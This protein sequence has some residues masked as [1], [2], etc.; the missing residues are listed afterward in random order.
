VAADERTP[1][2]RHIHSRLIDEE[3]VGKPLARSRL[4]RQRSIEGY[5]KGNAAPRWMSRLAEID[6]GIRRE[7]RELARL[8]A[9]L[10]ERCGADAERFAREWRAVAASR[11]YDHL[12]DLIEVHNE[13]YPIERDLPMNPRTGEYVHINGRPYTR[14]VLGPAWVLA[15]FPPG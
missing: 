13:W 9:E 3:G 8:H 2:E 1:A 4:Q 15:E 7:R 6:H 5:L 12:N 11:R 10:R 14:P